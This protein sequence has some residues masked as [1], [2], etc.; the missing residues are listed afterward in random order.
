MLNFDDLLGV[1]TFAAAGMFA[2]SAL[3]PMPSNGPVAA[4]FVSAV[5]AQAAP[6]KVTQPPA[7]KEQS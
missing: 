2:A 1:A 6:V 4:P 3:Q 7:P 5:A